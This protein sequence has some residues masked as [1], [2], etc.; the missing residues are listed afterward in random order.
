MILHHYHTQPTRKNG[1]PQLDPNL[2]KRS[3]FDIMHSRESRVKHQPLRKPQQLAFEVGKIDFPNNESSTPSA[4]ANLALPN[5]W[6]AAKC[7][8]H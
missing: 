2:I 4:V 7:Q 6:Y 1:L 8:T 5:R 3:S